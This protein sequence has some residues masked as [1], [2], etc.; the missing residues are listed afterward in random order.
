MDYYVTINSLCDPC[1][2]LPWSG[3]LVA[4]SKQEAPDKFAGALLVQNPHEYYITMY[5]MCIYIYMCVYIYI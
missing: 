5:M 1:A 2:P 4:T 3:E